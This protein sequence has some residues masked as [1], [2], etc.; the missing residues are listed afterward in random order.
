MGGAAPEDS[1]KAWCQQLQ[2]QSNFLHDIAPERVATIMHKAR[3]RLLR[4][5]SGRGG[6]KF[7]QDISQREVSAITQDWDISYSC[8][9]DLVPRAAFLCK[10]AKWDNIVWL[11]QVLCGPGFLAYRPHLWRGSALLAVFKDGNPRLQRSFRLVFVK[12]QLGLLQECLM[13]GRL[14]HTIFNYIHACQSGYC[15]G[16]DDPHLAMHELSSSAR[17]QLRMIWSVLGDFKKAFPR[18]WRELL[19]TL[20]GQGPQV[21]D[22][23]YELLAST[24]ESDSVHIW[25]S[26]CSVIQVEQGIPEGGALGPLCYNVLPDSLVKKLEAEGHG[27]GIDPD[28]PSV[29]VDHQ[30]C[31]G[32]SPDPGLVANLRQRLRGSGSLPPAGL[33]ATW[34]D[35]EAS[36]ARALDLE[37]TTRVPC[38]FHADDPLILSSSRGGLQQMLGV[39]SSWC[40]DCGAQFHVGP[41]KTVAMAGG[42]VLAEPS[43]LFFENGLG[44]VAL[45]SVHCHRWLGLLWPENLDFRGFLVSRLAAAST[46]LAQIAGLA[47]MHAV[48]WLAALK[49]FEAKVDSILEMGRWVFVM[50]PDA[51]ELLEVAYG[52]WAC[53]MLGADWWRNK[54]VCCS[55]LGWRLSGFAR[56][57]RSVALRR[58]RLW[59][60]G[61]SDWHAAFFRRAA[62]SG[63]GWAAKGLVAMQRWGVSDW[64]SWSDEASN[65]D[66][67]KR[68]VDHKLIAEC[69]SRWRQVADCH[70]AQVPYPL[71]ETS[72]GVRILSLRSMDLS[73]DTQMGLRSWCRLRCGALTLRHLDGRVSAARYQRCIFCGQPVRNATVHALGLCRYWSVQRADFGVAASVVHGTSCQVVA[74]M[75]LSG[76]VCAGALEVA[77]EWA[78]RIDQQEYAFWRSR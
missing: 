3:Q 52:K 70:Q 65:L 53:A 68:Y 33:L 71:L 26:G 57:V 7:D 29:W 12:V 5:R 1:H 73:A 43:G 37:A 64:P 45:V 56:V 23:M 10:H 58:A 9:P 55:E 14:K 48:P 51:E 38:I 4:A 27:F 54:A 39:I 32:G 16:V 60:R 63:C 18:T 13:A 36:A 77:V 31:C 20:L 47:A 49:I 61:G 78:R 21:Q 41:K 40:G 74:R 19:L 44:R 72:P 34:P 2:E 11:S 24:L 75:V 50:V 15:K 8:P 59:R 62:V 35:L 28:I 6:G 76:D 69:H 25:L 17:R 67:Y 66:D 30:W 46:N 22:G 42:F